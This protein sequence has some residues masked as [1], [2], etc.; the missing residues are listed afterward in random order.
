MK[1]VAAFL[2]FLSAAQAAPAL[3][4]RNEPSAK[5][6]IHHSDDVSFEKVMNDS[7]SSD[8]IN[9]V[10]LLK[11]QDNGDEALT[12][13]TSSGALPNVA[14]K[15]EHAH[16]VH[17]HVSNVQNAQ[18][19]TTMASRVGKGP[20]LQVTL[21]EFASK[22]DSMSYPHE[23]AMEVAS[24]GMVS[25]SVHGMNKRSRALKDAKVLVVDVPVRSGASALDGAVQHAIE[26]K[27]VGSV[28]LSSVRSVSE[29][30]YARDLLVHRR[31]VLMEKEGARMVQSRRRLDDANNQG[32]D[33]AD[34]ADDDIS[35]TYYV[36]MT[37]N[38]FAGLLFF[39]LFVVI[40]L[41]GISCMNMIS[42]QDTY[43]N[44]MP[45]V[46]REA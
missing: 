38:I 20:A 16:C 41:I 33:A 43:V 15:A 35:G 36:S 44:K 34:A 22:I 12:S 11:R 29:V 13:W 9:V 23:E 37:P 19:V 30:K 40:T 4:W 17:H 7:F 8:G 32:D 42:G 5:G 46:G 2:S 45:L 24:N 6:T 14:S 3:I 18:S 28:V 26:S 10:F 25:K 21:D 27:H 39:L 31:R 1:T